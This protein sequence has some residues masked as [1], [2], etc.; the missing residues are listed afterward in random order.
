MT[1]RSMPICFSCFFLTDPQRMVCAV[2]PKG[3]PTAI[4]NNEAD[5]RE[6]FKGDGGQQWK[7]KPGTLPRSALPTV[8]FGR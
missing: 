2:F 3:I 4:V 8:V 6:P 1:T 7:Q 5:H